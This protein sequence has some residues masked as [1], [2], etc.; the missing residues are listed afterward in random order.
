MREKLRRVRVRVDLTA[1]RESPLQEPPSAGALSAALRGRGW[2][3]LA[4]AKSEPGE[5][6]HPRF[7]VP[8]RVQTC[9]LKLSMNRQQEVGRRAPRAPLHRIPRSGSWSRL[10]TAAKETVLSNYG[11]GIDGLDGV[12]PLPHPGILLG[13]ATPPS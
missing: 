1:K 12:S 7:M 13:G 3:R 10:P 4:S 6:E 5:V 8:I 9:R 2:F 11:G